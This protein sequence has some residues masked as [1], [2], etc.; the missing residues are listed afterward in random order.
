MSDQTDL[1][2]PD[3]VE[4]Q[5]KKDGKESSKPQQPKTSERILSTALVDK[6]RGFFSESFLGT[7]GDARE[8]MRSGAQLLLLDAILNGL[9]D[10]DLRKLGAF[11]GL[12]VGLGLIE[13]AKKKVAEK[14]SSKKEKAN[15]PYVYDLEV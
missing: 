12:S 14:K 3:K 5:L 2:Q 13:V 9:Q 1:G 11:C 7:V 15:T 10:Y 4:K 6:T 8:K